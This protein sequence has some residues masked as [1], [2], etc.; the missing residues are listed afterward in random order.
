MPDGDTINF[1]AEIE[2]VARRLYGEP[3]RGHSNRRQLR[4]GA[5]GSL[6]VE[7][8]GDKRGTW[9]DHE[10]QVGGGT[11]ALIQHKLGLVN[12]EAL[13]WLGKRPAE[14]KPAGKQIVATYDYTDED[15][16][17]LYQAVRYEPKDFRQRR[18][19]GKGGW[20]WTLDDVRIVPYRL[21]TAESEGKR[22][23]IPTQGG[24]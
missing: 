21:P 8:G 9:Y 10:N 7:I 13:D 15:G 17:L 18:P 22:T 16:E 1:A 12:G 23:V 20:I 3:N 2:A 11:L 14:A 5:N 4:F 24:P 6:A 19:D